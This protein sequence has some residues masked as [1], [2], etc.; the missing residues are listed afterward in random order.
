MRLQRAFAA[1]LSP[2]THQH[3]CFNGLF[4]LTAIGGIAGKWHVKKRFMGAVSHHSAAD[5]PDHIAA[6][7]PALS[8]AAPCLE[9]QSFSRSLIEDSRISSRPSVTYRLMPV[10]GCRYMRTLRA[11]PFT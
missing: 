10:P 5:M 3:V 11:T 6:G 8:V 1:Q 4:F 2:R 9:N 7:K